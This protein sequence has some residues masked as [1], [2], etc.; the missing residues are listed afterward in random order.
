[1]HSVW[2][3]VEKKNCCEWSR[4]GWGHVHGGYR[5]HQDCVHQADR[6]SGNTEP[7]GSRLLEGER[8]IHVQNLQCEGRL[9]RLKS[10]FGTVKSCHF[11]GDC[12]PDGIFLLLRFP[13]FPSHTLCFSSS[14]F[15]LPIIYIGSLGA[16]DIQLVLSLVLPIQVICSSCPKVYFSRLLCLSEGNNSQRIHVT[17]GH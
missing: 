17:Q 2:K 10:S 6:S 8:N 14:F 11:T 3:P 5:S 16:M 13:F 7:V 9:L 12:W 1:M 15:P 4:W